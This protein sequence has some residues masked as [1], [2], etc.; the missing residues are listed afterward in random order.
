MKNSSLL[1][2]ITSLILFSCAT[3]KVVY[4]YDKK[5]NFNSYKTFDF[6]P[7]IQL[8]LSELDSARV[9]QQ[10]ESA[11]IL[12]GFK[13]SSTP[14]I[15]INIVSEQFETPSN[16]SIGIGLGTGGRNVGV[17]VS[18]GIPLRS[19]TLTQ[20]FRVDLIDVTKDVLIW[21]GTYEGKFKKRISPEA[22][23]EYFKITF[24][25]IFSGYPPK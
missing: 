23:N 19:N 25:K 18:G 21:E 6:Y 16:N 5:A 14:D 8:A 1:L 11:L 12:K 20:L 24:E 22:K 7:D 2:V 9:L 13:K 17:G 10:V 3:P 15:F 4:D